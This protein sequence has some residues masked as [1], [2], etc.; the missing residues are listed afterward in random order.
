MNIVLHQHDF[1]VCLLSEEP[2][3]FSLSE[4]LLLAVIPARV[5]LSSGGVRA[6][7]RSLFRGKASVMD[8]GEDQGACTSDALLAWSAAGARAGLDGHEQF[9]RRFG[10]SDAPPNDTL[11]I[12]HGFPESSFSFRKIIDTALTRFSQIVLVDH[13]GFGLSDKPLVYTY[14]LFEQADRLVRL[15]K[16]LGVQGGHVLAHDMGDS[17]ATELMARQAAGMGPVGFEPGLLSVTVTNGNKVMEEARLTQGQ[18][19]ALNTKTG[20]A[21]GQSNGY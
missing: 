3:N 2:I 10:A 18:K 5:V 1:P 17:I 19:L 12:L 20:T 16:T 4:G 11:L 8:K 13:L 14:S 6:I 15:W 7:T 21:F 9:I